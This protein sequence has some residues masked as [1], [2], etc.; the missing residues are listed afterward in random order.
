MLT[1]SLKRRICLYW[2]K[3][4]CIEFFKSKKSLELSDT[5]VMMIP[6][7]LAQYLKPLDASIKKPFKDGIRKKYNKNWLKMGY[8]D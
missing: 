8:R 4:Q 7:R 1:L 3:H 2:M 5:K 6:G